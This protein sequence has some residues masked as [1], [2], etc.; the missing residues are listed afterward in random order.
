M[1]ATELTAFLSSL[2][3]D[4]R[5]AASTQNQALSALL[6]LYRDVLELEVSWLDDLVRAKRPL[7]LS[8]VLTREEVGAVLQLLTGVP[9]LMASGL[10]GSGLRLLECCRL[11]VQ[12]VD[13][14]TD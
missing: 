11:R 5:V 10:Y 6:F 7:R 14:A 8:V 12:D 4:R 9:R 3:V 1:G 13:L 2:A